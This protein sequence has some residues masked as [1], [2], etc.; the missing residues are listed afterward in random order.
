MEI[1]FV[2][3]STLGL[4]W[5]LEVRRQGVVLGRVLRRPD[6]GAYRYYIGTENQLNHEY[7]DPDLDNLKRQVARKPG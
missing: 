2:E 6:T 4:P 5:Y 7:E 3:K 1:E